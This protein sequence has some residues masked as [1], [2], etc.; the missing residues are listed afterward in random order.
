MSVE[1][2]SDLLNAALAHGL[3]A[4]EVQRQWLRLQGTANHCRPEGPCTLGSGILKLQGA[5]LSQWAD[6]GERLSPDRVV[7]FIPASGAATRMFKALLARDPDSMAQLEAQ[8]DAFPFRDEAEACGP[9]DTVDQKWSAI[10]ER[11]ALHQRPKGAMPFHREPEGI[12]NAFEA[13]LAEWAATL[14][15]GSPEMH[16][17]LPVRDFDSILSDIR[18]AAAPYDMVCTASVQSPVTD[19]VAVDEQGQ[20]FATQ[21]GPLFRPGGHGALL[22][23]LQDLATAH[24]GRLISIK[25]IDNVRPRSAWSE[26]LPWRR[27][28][29][30][31]ADDVLD[32]RNAALD[33]L[34]TGRLEP[35]KHW[36]TAWPGQQREALP[37]DRDGLRAALDRP[38]VIAGM[39]RN[40]G[41][42]GGGPFW[43]RDDEGTLRA[44]IVESSE[45]D[46]RDAEV[47]AMV[48]KATHFNPV[49]LVCGLCDESGKPYELA[50]FVD[51]SRD[52]LVH[53]SH[54][55][56]ALRGLE[57]P[58]LWNGSMG[59]WNTVFVEIDPA[60]FAPVKTVFDLLRP[61]HRAG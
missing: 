26:V 15:T 47:R 53:K 27:A 12:Q 21:E 29:L 2:P 9:C 25:N 18:A 11:L 28:L 6:R 45:M 41:E 60:T 44:Q 3:T 5:E 57:H 49:D 54:E 42:P 10:L 23:N 36:L 59:R 50:Q 33:A 17:T 24:P 22:H 8:W 38:L 51:G 40:E 37:V 52:F 31:L 4:E 56:R 58:G 43:V 1:V 32:A 46:G 34:R 35:A 30:G 13:Q 39:V 20:P 61:A 48:A 7:R 19:A 14:S 55:G 16:F